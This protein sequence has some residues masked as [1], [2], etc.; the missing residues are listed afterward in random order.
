MTLRKVAMID[1]V[2]LGMAEDDTYEALRSDMERVTYAP[3]LGYRNWIFRYKSIYLLMFCAGNGHYTYICTLNWFDVMVAKF[4]A[5][6]D[7]I[8]CP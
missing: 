7:Q 8:K 3:N 2:L 6:I 5:M 1:E 4:C